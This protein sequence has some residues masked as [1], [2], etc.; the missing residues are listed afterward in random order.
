MEN[1]DCCHSLST[2]AVVDL[3]EPEAVRFQEP[4]SVIKALKHGTVRH[5]PLL[6]THQG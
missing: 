4:Q 3:A 2:V 5:M 1:G 6:D